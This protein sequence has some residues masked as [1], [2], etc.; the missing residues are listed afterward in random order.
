MYR[1]EKLH[2]VYLNDM[3]R[4]GKENDGGYVLSSKQV[5]STEILLSFGI[6]HDWSFEADFLNLKK[7]RLYA[8]DHSVSMSTFKRLT[9]EH[10]ASMLGY[11]LTCNIAEVK[12]YRMLLRY[13]SYISKDFKQ[14]FREESQRYFI[15]KFVGEYDN[16]KYIRL[17]TVLKNLPKET[18]DLSVFI[19]MDIENWEYLTLPQSLPFFDKINGLAVEFHQLDIAGKVFEETIDLLS[20]QFYIAHVHANNYDKLIYGTDL[21]NTIEVTLINKALVPDPIPSTQSY[22]LKGLDFPCDKNCSDIPLHFQS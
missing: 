12:R 7:V 22:P 5:E 10:F 19:K 16:E 11:L 1:L 15:P 8:Y 2:P 14:F 21:P 6:N 9:Q 4:V 18:K 20:S 13:L 17:D 3:V